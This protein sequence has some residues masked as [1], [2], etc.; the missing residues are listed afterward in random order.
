[1]TLA[2]PFDPTLLLQ[3]HRSGENYTHEQITD[4]MQDLKDVDPDFVEQYK[5]EFFAKYER[6]VVYQDDQVAVL[7]SFLD[8]SAPTRC[9]VFSDR[10]HLVQSE[11]TLAVDGSMDRSTLMLDVHR[12]LCVPFAWLNSTGPLNVA[13]LGSGAATL[14]LFL[15]EHL[16]HI[17]LLD[18]VEPSVKVNSIAREFFGVSQAEDSQ[19]RKFRLHQVMG[20]EFIARTEPNA[21]YDLLVIDVEAGGPE[22]DIQAPPAS[23]L[24]PSFLESAKNV[25][26]SDGVIAINVIAKNNAALANVQ[27]RV[28]SVFSHGLVLKL[29]SNSVFFASSSPQSPFTGC[30]DRAKLSR[31]LARDSFQVQK[32]RTP[33]LLNSSYSITVHRW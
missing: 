32:A 30:D 5:R 7:D 28:S 12:A 31:F 9:F 20:E 18:A 16:D 15:L 6:R 26:T 14:P 11:V 8:G 3:I 2:V 24:Q 4:L 13:V 22:D 21:K 17:T 29:R 10:L 25:L 27:E 19:Q 23:M 33:A 1:M